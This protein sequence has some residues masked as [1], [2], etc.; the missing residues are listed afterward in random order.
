MNDGVTCLVCNKPCVSNRGLSHHLRRHH[1]TPEEYTLKYLC[2]GVNPLCRC[3]CKNPTK[4]KNKKY[5]FN[6]FVHNHHKPTLGREMT[7]E[8]KDMISSTLKAYNQTLTK[9]QRVKNIQK[10]RQGLLLKRQEP[11][12]LGDIKAKIQSAWRGKSKSEILSIVEK[13]KKTILSKYGV[14]S[15][16][17]LLFH[18]ERTSKMNKLSFEEILNICAKKGYKPLFTEEEYTGC[19]VFLKFLCEKHNKVFESSI[20]NVQQQKFNQCRSCYSY[21]TGISNMERE[22]FSFVE[23]IISAKQNSR[24]VIPPY[25]LDI[26]VPTHNIAIEFNGLYWHSEI[27]KP[28]N[29]HLNKFQA[30]RDKGIQLLQIYE[31]EWRDKRHIWESIIKV[32]L[33]V[34][35]TKLNARELT[36]DDN[37]SVK[38]V[39][40]F[41]DKNHLQGYC[42]S[43]KKFALKD[44]SDNIVFCITFR[45]PFTKN[46]NDTIEVARVCSE[47][48][49][50][51]RGAFSKIMKYAIQW[52]K[53]EGYEKILTYSDCRYSWGKSYKNYGFSFTSHTGFGYDYTDFF[54]RHGRFQFRANDGK[55]EKQ[56]AVD[57][58]VCK[59]YNAGNYRWELNL[60]TVSIPKSTS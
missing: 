59:I 53:E 50:V 3:G 14:D 37:P 51:I 20:F 16:M 46:K 17:K 21:S 8:Q 6:E 43:N 11:A 18:R 44:K 52:A 54:F 41:L 13:R 40:D 29:Y 1:I 22:V 25:E 24:S 26:Y 15:V 5:R 12:F 56:I 32:N 58:E 39:R 36:V 45:K 23:S 7:R 30:C 35:N 31:D 49:V 10:T 2:E 27:H 34:I 4:Y 57:N 60:E 9:E 38:E 19:R 42:K 47:V 28:N 48:G 33:G 55:S